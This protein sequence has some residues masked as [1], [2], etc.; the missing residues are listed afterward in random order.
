MNWKFE[1]IAG[2]YD[3]PLG[4]LA[5]DGAGMLFSDIMNSTIYR[6]DPKDKGVRIWRKH[7]NRTNG[8]AFGEHKVLYG[9]QEGS[10]RVVRYESDGSTTLTTQVMRDGHVHNHP[11][12]VTVDRRGRVWCCDPYNEL[13]TWGPQLF[14]KLEHAS[15]LRLSQDPAPQRRTWVIDRMTFDTTNPRGLALSPDERILYVS[16]NNIVEDGCRELRAYGILPDGTL[17]KPLV[18][19]TFGKDVRGAQRGIEGI[20]VAA[21]GNVLGCGGW[22]RNGP[23]P[24]IYVFSPKGAIIGTHE[25]PGD[26]PVQ[27]AFGDAGLDALYVTTGD[28][29][30]FRARRTGLR[31]GRK[32]DR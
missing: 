26:L 11:C 20:C 24:L 3:G 6:F 25:I 30:L 32:T 4:G 12:A 16:E 15:V 18:M 27:C 21:D 1:R 17:A 5:W 8:I 10:R 22:K 13:A 23:G 31:G 2:P 7:T 28:G 9:C 29:F 14:G 19:C